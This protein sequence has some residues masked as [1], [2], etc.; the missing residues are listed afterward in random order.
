MKKLNIALVG[1]P[2]SGKT[3]LFNLLV[4]ANYHVA[5]YPGITVERKH[6]SIKYKNNDLVFHDLPGTYSLSAY[7]QEEIITRD[8]ILK[9]KPDLIVQVVDASNLQRNLYLTIQLLE[10]KV[11]VLIALNM[12][13][14]AEKRKIEIDVKLLSKNMDLPIIPIIARSGKGKAELLESIIDYNLKPSKIDILSITYGNDIDNFLNNSS[15]LINNEYQN[16][17][18]WIALKYLEN[19]ETII[20]ENEHKDFHKDLLSDVKN[21]ENHIK[22]TLDT[23]PEAVIADYRYGVVR[24]ITKEV[25]TKK[26]HSA[27]L[28]ATDIIDKV[29][30]QRFLGP[31]ILFI[32]LYFI[33]KF[34]FWVSEYPTGLLESFFSYISNIVNTNLSDGLV[35]S[36]LISGIIDG[37]GGV[38]GFT[39]LIFFM[40]FIIAILEDSGYMARMAYILDRVFKWFGLQ[41]NSVVPFIVSGGIAGGCAVPGVMASRTIKGARERLLTI[42]T[43]PFMACGAKIPVYALLIS[44]FFPGDKSIAMI[45]IIILSWIFSLIIAK[46]YSFLIIKGEPSS[47]I[48]ELPPYR[49]PILKGL[50]VHAWERTWLYI[51]KAGTV[52]LFISIILWIMMTFPRLDNKHNKYFEDKIQSVKNSYGAQIKTEFDKINYET[53]LSKNAK[54]LKEKIVEI[55]NE[56]AQLSLKNS[57]AGKIGTMLSPISSLA[58]FDWRTNI[59]LIGGFAAKEVVVSTLG[60]A[61]SLGEVDP[62]DTKSLS[63]KLKNDPKWSLGV[64]IAL[65][66]FTILYAPCFVAVVAIIKET[67]SFKWGIFAVIS[68]TFIAFIFSILAYQIFE[69]LM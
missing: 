68:N 59:A 17:N 14:V 45:G 23:Y 46:A 67:A 69:K 13:D 54:E 66:I 32:I 42:L 50:F 10:M 36:L 56:R 27:R 58:G 35:K 31:L 30:T 34:I 37:V 29:L 15:L 21:V 60:M 64:A 43:A 8:Y 65:I 49:I 1:N 57:I 22:I 41:G 52:I 19:D 61:Y 24:N 3:T 28:Y 5:N 48:M 2:N 26:D 11:P 38:L 25:L 62:V 20:K 12:M 16:A 4:G 9:D 18:R 47:F 7:S 6:S 40:F 53:K 44:A 55:E 63:E 33:Y 39:P 51:K